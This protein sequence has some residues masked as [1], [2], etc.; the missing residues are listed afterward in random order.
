MDRQTRL[1]LIKRKYAHLDGMRTDSKQRT[2]LPYALCKEEGID[3]TGMSPKEA[4]EAYEKKTGKSPSDVYR[5]VASGEMGR[6]KTPSGV[7]YPRLKRGV[8]YS[9]VVRTYE[10]TNKSDVENGMVEDGAYDRVVKNLKDSDIVYQNGPDGREVASIPF[11]AAKVDNK[12]K[13]PEVQKVY[14]KIFKDGVRAT[15]DLLK[16]GKKEGIYFEGIENAIKGASHVE[17]KIPLQR[18]KDRKNGLPERSDAEIAA[19][20]GDAVRFTAVVNHDNYVDQINKIMSGMEKNGYKVV[21]LDNKFLKPGT[22]Y[23]AVHL[24][25]EN[26]SGRYME[27]QIQSRETQAIKDKNHDVYYKEQQRIERNAINEGRE[28]TESEKNRINELD[29]MMVDSWKPMRVPKGMA[30]LKGFDY[31][32]KG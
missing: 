3:T 9:D 11:L 22:N 17:G 6:Q 18:E 21:E 16:V 8:K 4:W 15:N 2:R 26:P 13:D 7:S 30:Q 27:L 25:V 1:R 20:L 32:R 29:Q 23:K 5:S 31:R 28:L 24:T 10:E 19:G 12:C 14:D